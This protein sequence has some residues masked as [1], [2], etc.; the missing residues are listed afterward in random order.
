MDLRFTP[1]EI[2]WRDEVRTFINE[3]L[4]PEIRERMR[5]GYAPT[6]QETIT[7]QRILNKKGWACPG[8][9]AE[10]GGA[11]WTP[12]QRM[13]FTEENQAAPAPELNGFNIT[14]LGPVLAHFGTPEQ[15]A[16]FLPRAANLDEWWCQGFSEPG[17][18]SDLASL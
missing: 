3:N 1:E 10:F 8:W 4:P 17:A 13:I 5:L 16:Y 11:A 12:I 18:G 7:W 15:K 2:A 9:P 14:M 6:K